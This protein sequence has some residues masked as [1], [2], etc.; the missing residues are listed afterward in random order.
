[1]QHSP[2]HRLYF[3]IILGFFVLLTIFAIAAQEYILA[4]NF[5]ID[6]H[7]GQSLHLYDDRESGGDSR[8][9]LDNPGTMEWRCELGGKYDYPF[10]GFE[11]LLDAGRDS[12]IDLSNFDRVRIWLDY[13]GPSQ[14]LRVYLRNY[15]PQYSNK[16]V[17]QSTKYNQI[18]FNVNLLN[19][20]AEFSLRDFFVAN[21][22][23]FDNNIPPHLSRPQFDN[24]TIF[25]VQTG[26]GRPLGSHSFR[27]RKV[28]FVGQALSTAD[29]Y[30][31]IMVAW[32]VIILA[33]LAYR[34][35][36][37]K[38]EVTVQRKRE[39]ELLEINQLLDA[40]GKAL[41]LKAKKDP[42]T[43]A[44]NRLGLEEAFSHG[45]YEWRN[46][47]KPLSLVMMDID[48]FKRIND[49]HGHDVGD[50]ILSRLTELVHQHIRTQDLFARWGGE[51]FVLICRDTDLDNATAIAE[52]LRSLIANHHYPHGI[53]VTASFGVST[54]KTNQTLEQLFKSADS[55]L[56]KAKQTGRNKVVVAPSSQLSVAQVK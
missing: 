32:I 31:T 22:W 50:V 45:L 5:V 25:E 52:K 30:L 39:S 48:H 12:G 46:N 2:K 7:T 49:K 27:L 40:Q 51:E 17:R 43:G 23:V 41:E 38:D 21:W 4:R 20:Y 26:S 9:Y 54:L 8:I 15:D 19:G 42:L 29:W 14:T 35:L 10:C 34:I 24:I 53:S 16:E 55:A 13:K 18:E 28:E 37:L 1:M 11:V 33:Y 6:N 36:V 56:Y 44:F 3:D 47:K